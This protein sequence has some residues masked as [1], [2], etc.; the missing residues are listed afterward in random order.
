MPTPTTRPRRGPE[1][2]PGTTQKECTPCWSAAPAGRRGTSSTLHSTRPE[3]RARLADLRREE[4]AAGRGDHR[5]RRG[6]HAGLPRLGDARLGGQRQSRHPSPRRR[7]TRPS[8]AWWPWCAGPGPRSWWST[9]T[10]SPATP[11]PTISGSTRSAWPRS[12]RRATRIAIPMPVA[13]WQPDKLYYTVFSVARF[14][15]IHEK[16]EELGL[17]SPFDEQWRKRWE[18][19]PG[20]AGHHLH[21]HFGLRRRSPRGVCW[22]MPPRSTPTPRFWFGLPPEVMRSIH[23]FDDYRLAQCRPDRDRR[24]TRP[25][26]A[27]SLGDEGTSKPI[28]S[29]ACGQRIGRSGRTSPGAGADSSGRSV[30]GGVGDQVADGGVVRPDPSDRGRPARAPAG[31]RA[32]SSARSRVVRT[33]IVSCYWVLEAGRLRSGRVGPS[34]TPM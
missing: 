20:G 6:R 33:A 22:P 15:E 7:T 31:C 2:S 4:L 21:R 18:D 27:A 9:A 29:P 28:S 16:F 10:S 5:L 8:D 11:I 26:V 19:D 32:G 23:P 3:V 34:T 14:R 1:P 25:P 13:A 12:R 30:T 24:V 17:E